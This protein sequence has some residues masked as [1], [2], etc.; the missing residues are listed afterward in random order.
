MVN[1]II[2]TYAVQA[3]N[4]DERNV[5]LLIL[6]GQKEHLHGNNCI[7]D[8]DSSLSKGTEVKYHEVSFEVQANSHSWS[9][10]GK[11]SMTRDKAGNIVWEEIL[12]R[13]NM[14]VL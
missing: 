5:S 4:R 12:H 10:K 13:I 8:T 6:V 1:E 7:V 11:T 2:D 3:G 9:I 14:L